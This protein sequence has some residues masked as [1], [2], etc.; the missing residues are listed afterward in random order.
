MDVIKTAKDVHSDVIQWRRKLHQI[1]ELGFELHKTSRFVR[2]R[3]EEM[4]IEYEVIAKTGICAIIKGSKP[5]PTIA[6]R[7]DMDALL[8]K[9]ETGLPYASTNDN[10]HACGHDAHTAML[11]GAARILSENKDKLKGNVKLFFQP[12]EENE[13]GAQPMIEAG[14]MENPQVDAV[15]GLHVGALFKEVGAGK[16]G[17]HYGPAMAAVDKFSVKVRGKGGH[18]AAPHMCVD[19]I[20]TACEIITNL[21]KIVSREINP[22]HPAVLSVGTIRGGTAFNIIPEVVEFEGTV[23]TTDPRDREFIQKRFKEMCETIARANRAEVEIDYLNHYPAAIN[24]EEFTQQFVKSAENVIGKQN[25][26]ELRK[27]TMGAED[28][29]YFLQKAPGTFFFLG[30]NNPEKGI[31]YPNHHPKFDVD[32]DVLWIGPALFVQAV[33]DFFDRPNSSKA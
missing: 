27:P 12:A 19:P 32:E 9:E 18:G 29:A 8:L 31:I 33:L 24:D 14:C 30:T 26:V 5:G 4:G 13:G 23:R 25:I 20:A 21:Q 28:M 11:L 10:M 22:T 3:L 6:L 1:P 16:I 15:L 2:E 7:A 17:I